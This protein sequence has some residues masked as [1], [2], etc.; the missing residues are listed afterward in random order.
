MVAVL[1]VLGKPAAATEPTDSTLDNPAHGFNHEAFGVIGA[2][3]DFNQQ[4]WHDVD[5]AVLEDWPCIGAVCEQL[6]EER[7]LS[8]QGGQQQD[9]AV[10][11]LDVSRRHQ[12]VQHQT[13]CIDKDMA[14]LA[15]DQLA[16]IKAV[17][18]DA[19][20]P[21]SALFT[22]WLSTMPAVGLAS[23]SARSRHFT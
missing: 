3:D 8:E 5:G 16:R 1:P 2:F 7:E 6:S 12:H 23:R 13:E 4:A 10:P 9:A 14:F 17:W 19:G 18:I 21:F 15:F 11:V 20:P 22:L